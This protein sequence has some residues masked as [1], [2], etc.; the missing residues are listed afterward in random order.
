ML[1]KQHDPIQPS[2][3]FWHG[4]C[5]V[6]GIH[7]AIVSA[8][9]RLYIY[10]F[11]GSID[12]KTK[13]GYERAINLVGVDIQ[14][15]NEADYSVTINGAPGLSKPITIMPCGDLSEKARIYLAVRSAALLAPSLSGLCRTFVGGM[16]GVGI[17]TDFKNTAIFLSSNKQRLVLCLRTSIKQIGQPINAADADNTLAI[18]AE[19]KG[20]ISEEERTDLQGAA[21]GSSLVIALAQNSILGRKADNCDT[22]RLR[23]ALSRRSH[24]ASEISSNSD[25][26]RRLADNLISVDKKDT[27]KV[28][29]YRAKFLAASSLK[30]SLS[31]ERCCWL[32]FTSLGYDI[33]NSKVSKGASTHGL[34]A[35]PSTIYLKI[36]EQ[37]IIGSEGS[38]SH[39]ILG[40][41]QMFRSQIAKTQSF[42]LNS[43]SIQP[44]GSS[45]GGNKSTKIEEEEG[46]KESERGDGGLLKVLST[47]LVGA[48]LSR[49][50]LLHSF[51]NIKRYVSGEW[52]DYIK[53]CICR[54][55]E[56]VRHWIKNRKRKGGIETVF[57]DDINNSKS[58][59]TVTTL[60]PFRADRIAA[61][62]GL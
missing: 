23:L 25:Y 4:E 50:E 33:D 11:P 48:R 57:K 56:A 46:E 34:F 8:P 62:K 53:V 20:N 51:R 44:C 59:A 60:S 28:D 38:T 45:G 40:V 41:R 54:C 29:A 55:Q 47:S 18:I 21:T 31:L 3:W 17:D 16:K 15:N 12:Q 39:R 10:I 7:D 9:V 35:A 13:S 27:T 5:L 52:I 37:S 2:F 6:S 22:R 30:L 1:N 36:R 58:I 49:L 61:L 26:E 24:L 43:I 19:E 32:T 42:W 14:S